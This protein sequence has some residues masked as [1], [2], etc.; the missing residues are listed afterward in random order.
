[1]AGSGEDFQR[2]GQPNRA[3]PN[4]L[5][6]VYGSRPTVF[7]FQSPHALLSSLPPSFRP[8]F[9]PSI[10]P[11]IHQWRRLSITLVYCEGTE[12]AGNPGSSLGL[13]LHEPT[14]GLKAVCL[15]CLVSVRPNV[16]GSRF[17]SY[18]C[19]GWKTLPGG[20]QC[21]VRKSFAAL[22][23]FQHEYPLEKD[24]DR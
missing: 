12:Q 20:N 3:S 14:W 24:T 11:S 2:T 5:I 15:L 13:C 16:C 22:A 21:I 4:L 23:S 10:H 17:H 1:M 8:S 18:C 6:Q 9:P 7:E 19:P